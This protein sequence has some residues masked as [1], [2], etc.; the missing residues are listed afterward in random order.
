MKYLMVAMM[1]LSGCAILNKEDD[2]DALDFQTP[3]ARN[4]SSEAESADLKL[5]ADINTS[6]E[7]QET[8]SELDTMLEVKTLPLRRSG[9][10]YTL[11]VGAFPNK[12][13]A[14]KSASRLG[15]QKSLISF[16][17]A[18]VNGRTW[19]R[20]LVGKFKDKQAALAYQKKM[21]SNSILRSI[22]SEDQSL[23][24]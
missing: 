19:Q 20:V 14:K 24:H 12:E 4:L 2:P 22:T 5:L 1:L 17:S 21:A 6:V 3:I 10:Y 8:A 16:Q 9:A 23:W 18:E 15:L 13:L 11:Q 7:P